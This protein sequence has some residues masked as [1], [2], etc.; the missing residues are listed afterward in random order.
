MCPTCLG[1]TYSLAL[2]SKEVVKA[3]RV[4]LTK[5]GFWGE[6]ERKE[7]VCVCVLEDPL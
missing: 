1:L 3:L 5:V 6:R 7:M 4:I 2:Y